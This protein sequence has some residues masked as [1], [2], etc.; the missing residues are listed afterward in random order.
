MAIEANQM[1][2]WAPL[3]HNLSHR[4]KEA[5]RALVSLYHELV[6]TSVE[7]CLVRGH[8]LVIQDV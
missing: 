5:Q 2:Q 7:V 6:M 8:H 3:E 4:T 1:G